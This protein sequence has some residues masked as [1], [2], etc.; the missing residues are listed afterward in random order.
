MR[1]KAVTYGIVHL[2]LLTLVVALFCVASMADSPWWR[3]T[4]TTLDL[5]LFLNAIIASIILRGERQA[6]ALGY[7][8]ASVFFLMSLYTLVGIE[9]LP[10]MITQ[11]LWTHMASISMSPPPE[12]HFY[13]VA[14]LFWAFS[15]GYF[16][17]MLAKRWHRK[18]I[19]AEATAA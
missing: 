18:R 13:I 3:A 6:F 16:G 19:A 1:A 8:V 14:A 10:L 9:T 17:G 12:E 5:C 4:L 7:A 15:C 2:M 11:A